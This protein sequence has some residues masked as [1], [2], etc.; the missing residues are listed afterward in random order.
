MAV[1]RHVTWGGLPP[2]VDDGAEG[3]DVALE[4]A[5]FMDGTLPGGRYNVRRRLFK[6]EHS[7]CARM[8]LVCEFPNQEG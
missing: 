8:A 7:A 3:V 2:V 4:N 1:L 5:V 6:D